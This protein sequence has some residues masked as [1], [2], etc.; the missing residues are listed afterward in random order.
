A[1][2]NIDSSSRD[3][4]KANFLERTLSEAATHAISGGASRADLKYDL[5]IASYEK[6]ASLYGEVA[7]EKWSEGQ[8]EQQLQ[9]L[10]ALGDLYVTVG[11]LAKARKA[12][13]A[14]QA[15]AADL[16]EAEPGNRSWKD[17][18]AIGTLKMGDVQRDQGDSKG[19]LSSYESG[20]DLRKDLA[21]ADP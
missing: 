17:R 7:K 13:E 3:A 12:F 4:L 5:A 14:G 1:A 2:A 16:L 15:T 8:R 20:L 18:L 11:D 21:S 9:T 19:A 10:D 6:A